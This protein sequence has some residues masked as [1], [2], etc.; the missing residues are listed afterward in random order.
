MS[1]L[2][3]AE[4]ETLIEEATVDAYG[5]DEQRTGLFTMLEEHLEVP[6]TTAVL[7]VEVPVRG[8]D[9]SP[10]GRIVALCSHGRA[11]QPIDILDLPLPAPAPRGAQWIEAYRYWAG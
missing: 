11:R 8:V 6:F 2:G 1:T 4:L 10:D 3:R 7:G 5:E 9:L